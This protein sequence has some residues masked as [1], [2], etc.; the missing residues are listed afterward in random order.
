MTV[1]LRTYKLMKMVNGVNSKGISYPGQFGLFLGL[2]LGGVVF[3]VL[4]SFLIWVGMTGVSMPST[5]E[6]VMQAKYYSVN[7]V[8]QGASSFLIF[9]LPIYL[10]AVICYYR[11]MKYLGFSNGFTWKQLIVVILILLVTFPLSGGLAAFNK[12]LPIP[13]SWTNY[14]TAMEAK[15]ASQEAVLIQINSVS[16]YIIS[17][18]SI[19]LLPAVFEE[20]FF[21]AGLQ[22]LLTNW[23]RRK[24]FAI[25]LTSII[26][27][28]I[29]VSY[30]GFLVRFALGMI[31][32]LVYYYSGSLWLNCIMHF[33]FN[34]LQV[35]ALYLF[36]NKPSVSKPDIET[37]FPSWLAIVSLGLI[38]Y[39]FMRFIKLSSNNEDL[40]A[41]SLPVQNSFENWTNN[42]I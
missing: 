18:I 17:I 8:I 28:L 5:P 32:G 13:I 39:L 12:W 7:M 40:V 35:T 37:G 20:T 26:F 27:S 38:I 6:L 3:G 25:I 31:L 9:F 24:W 14:F 21:R 11:P 2:T 23:T 36:Q 15:R 10:F 16:K 4:I 34:G 30:Y 22:K 42:S 33:L 29:H 1:N 19:A 41:E